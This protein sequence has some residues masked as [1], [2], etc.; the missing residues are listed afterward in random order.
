MERTKR[1][2]PQCGRVIYFEGLC[3]DCRQREKR[4]AYQALTETEIAVKIEASIAA[5]GADFYKK[6]ESYDFLNLLAY[7]GVSTERIA[8][9]AANAGVYYPCELYRDAAPAVREKL[10]ALLM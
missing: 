1:N 7:R 9:A 6:D 10:I 5:M 8:E 3:Y 4:E 2:C